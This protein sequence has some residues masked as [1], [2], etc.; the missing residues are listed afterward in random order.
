MPCDYSKY[1]PN[2]KAEIRPRILKRANNKCE[3]CFAENYSWG[4]WVKDGVGFLTDEVIINQLENTG[5]DYFDHELSHY[6]PED[7]ARKI[8]LTVSHL[9]HDPENWNVKDDRLK[10]LCQKCHLDYD[11]EHHRG[12]RVK[13]K[14]EK[15]GQM[16]LL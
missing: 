14:N 5:Y 8:V 1:P 7:H 4:F 12:N 15:T 9:D 11:R 16:E 6:K 13:N 3:F 2:L 10:A